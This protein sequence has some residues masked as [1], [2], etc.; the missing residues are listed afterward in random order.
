MLS[1]SIARA[2]SIP[3]HRA[4]RSLQDIEHIVVLMQE[5]RSFDHYFGV[6]RGVRGFGDPHPVVLPSGRP[7]W[8]QSD[9]TTVVPPFRPDVANLG[10]TFLQDLD[11]GW[12]GTHEM[13]NGG[14]WDQW[15]AAKTPASMAHMQRSDL[16]FHYALAD[17]FTVCDGY[18]CAMLGPTDPNRYH[19]WTGWDGNDG[20]GGGPVIANDELGYDWTTYPEHLQAAGVSWKIY[21]DVGDGLDAA[22][23]WGWTSDPYI[24]NYGTTRFCTSISI[25][26]PIRARRSTRGRVPGPT[27]RPEA[28]TSTSWPAMSEAASCRTSRGSSPP[29]LC[30]SIRSGRAATERAT[31]RGFSTR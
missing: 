29:R 26:P 8:Y 27:S 1:D 18:H 31:R 20:Q 14:Q 21:Q 11:H 22:G 5:N 28:H 6:M 25:S 9:G 3:A 23:Y 15:L 10:L 12:N 7:V 17:A 13:F 4:T 30:V 16:P 2:V 19:M 24:G